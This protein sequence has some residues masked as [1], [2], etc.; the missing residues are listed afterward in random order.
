MS[1]GL[2]HLADRLNHLFSVVP[3]PDGQLWKIGAAAEALGTSR[4]HLHRMLSGEQ[5]NPSAQ[6]LG[7]IAK[8]FGVPVAY[9]YDDEKAADVDRQLALLVAMRDTKV[10]SILSR[11]A[12]VSDAGLDSVMGVLEHVRRLEGLGEVGTDDAERE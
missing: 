7:A 12:G 3:G 8:L 1:D 4:K 11:S 6:L 5:S 9:F 10:R 2:P